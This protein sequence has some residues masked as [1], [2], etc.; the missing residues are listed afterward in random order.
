MRLES[1]AMVSERGVIDI[2]TYC[3]RLTFTSIMR[4]NVALTS[5]L[6][7]HLQRRPSSRRV[8]VKLDGIGHF[9]L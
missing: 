3:K 2:L 4:C 5:E 9:T 1:C 6:D 8:K 7:G